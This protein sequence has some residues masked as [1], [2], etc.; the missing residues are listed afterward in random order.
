MALMAELAMLGCWSLIDEVLLYRRA[1]KHH[2]TAM[3]SE[4]DIAE[5]FNPGA[6]ATGRFLN[7]RRH[8]DFVFSAFASPVAMRERLR[9]AGA[10]V[11]GLYWD[12]SG[13]RADFQQL[14]G[15]FGRE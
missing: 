1:G 12:R 8:L 11:Q 10:A 2:F 4:R 15:E 3:R 13:I 9:A 14:R 7:L 5:L 6:S